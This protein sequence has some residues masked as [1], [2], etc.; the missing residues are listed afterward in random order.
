M[1]FT[2]FTF[3]VAAVATCLW[4]SW[5]GE[6]ARWV[7]AAA[8]LA[9]I[10]PNA[11]NTIWET[12]LDDPALFA[13]DEAHR[14]VIRKDDR[15]LM[16]PAWGANMRWQAQSGYDFRMAG[17]YAGAFPESY[18]RYPAWRM[19]LSG[20]LEP[21]YARELRRFVRDKGVTVVVQD[22]RYGEPWNRMFAT[23]GVTP[24]EVGGM[25][26]YRLRPLRSRASMTHVSAAR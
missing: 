21:G 25:L 26:V 5:R 18:Q 4:L 16:V 22:S 15:V 17:G 13:R 24:R 20:R 23:L 10:L 9:F 14:A 1:R 11:G 8:A 3:L 2:G 19:L 6:P 12:P 7:V